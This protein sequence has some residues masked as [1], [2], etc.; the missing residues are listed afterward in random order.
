[1][2]IYRPLHFRISPSPRNP[3][4]LSAAAGQRPR[5]PDVSAPPPPPYPASPCGSV[6]TSPPPPTDAGPQA[7]RWPVRRPTGPLRRPPP[8]VLLPDAAA[9]LRRAPST[10]RRPPPAFAARRHLT[11]PPPRPASPRVTAA[12]TPPSRPPP[13]RRS[14]SGDRAGSGCP[15]TGPGLSPPSPATKAIPAS[16]VNSALQYPGARSGSLKP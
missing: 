3:K 10:A 7:Q 16:S 12:T 4:N 15:L 1:M 6:P 14:I 11:R 9:C 8:P 5:E 13:P 2:P